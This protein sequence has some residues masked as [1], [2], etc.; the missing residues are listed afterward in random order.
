MDWSIYIFLSMM[1]VVFLPRQFQVTVVENVNEEHLKKALWLFPLYLLAINIFVLPIT[2]GG[3]ML[4]ADGQVDADTF[5]L[6]LPMLEK[7]EGLALL[8]FIGGMSAATGMVVVETIA[9]STMICNDLVMPVLLRLPFID[10]SQRG[11]ISNLL[12]TIRRG[13]IVLVLL[14]GYAYYRVIGEFY[15]LVSIG[16]VSFVAVAQFAPPI[17]G[18]IFWKGGTRVGALSGLVAGFLVW[19][20]TLVIPSLVQAGLFPARFVT[21]GPFDWALFK[22][23]QMFGLE[24]FDHI[25]HAVFWSMLANIGA[26]VGG[27]V[28]FSRPSAIEHTQAAL[29]VDVFKRTQDPGKPA[30]W[31]GTASV[32]DLR[33]LLIRFLG[34]ERAEE[35]LSAYGQQHNINWKKASTADAGLVNYAEKLLAGVVGSASAHVM[36]ST[37]VK[38]EQLRIE[39][40]MDILDETRQVIAYSRKLE[41][42]TAELQAANER[43]K[44]LDRLKDEFISTVTHELKTPLTSV[45]ALA[46]ILHDN[47]DISEQQNEQFTSI[48]VKE[49]D[50]LTRL[51]VQVLEF[52]KIKSGKMEWQILNVDFKEVIQDAYTATRQ[53]MEDKQIQLNVNNPEA[54]PTVKGDKDRLVQVMVNLISNAV[55]FCPS[56]HGMIWIKV[57]NEN[58]RLRV[59]VKDN[60][61]GVRLQDQAAIFEEFRQVKHASK[62]RPSGTGLGLPITKRIIT[63]HGGEIWITSELNQGATFSFY[64]PI[65]KD[66]KRINLWKDS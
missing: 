63:H 19:G 20:Y 38:S 55:K 34:R 62:G 30:F 58:E 29:F 4:F 23:F 52:Q 7:R 46:E 8:V 51:I 45:R 26:Y 14:F 49:I 53:L 25:A 57:W 9:L 36:V 44:E 60:G 47:P 33:V 5:V 24:G 66:L 27:S 54:C 2:F 1:A 22:P 40:V 17:L 15:A 31:R 61:I 32:P 13:S 56:D 11:D 43:L 64:L 41:K 37:V 48:I 39:E 10:L 50:R 65:Q 16:L 3:V 59:D 28:F 6:T 35:A 21:H 12:L 42:A 18:G